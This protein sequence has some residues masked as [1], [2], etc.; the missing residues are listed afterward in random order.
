[1]R[2]GR[3]LGASDAERIRRLRVAG[4]LSRVASP[5]GGRRGG[6]FRELALRLVSLRGRL[7]DSLRIFEGLL[8]RTTHHHLWLDRH[9]FCRV[10]V[11]G[12][13][14][15]TGACDPWILE[16]RFDHHHRTGPALDG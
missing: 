10:R 9:W 1:Y 5:G 15:V 12:H 7:D 2:G 6:T 4:D 13:G 11:A 3:A 8:S 16:R 14:G